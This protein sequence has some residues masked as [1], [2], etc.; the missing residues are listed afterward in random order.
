[1][2]FNTELLRGNGIEPSPKRE[3]VPP[4]SQTVSFQYERMEDLER[5]FRREKSGYAYTRVGNPTITALERRISDLERGFSAICCSSGMSALAAAILAIC[6]SGDEILA[7]N[8]FYGGTYDLFRNLDRLGIRTVFAPEGSD[9]REFVTERTR[10]IL[11]ELI[12]NPSLS[13]LDVPRVADVA[14][15][16]G[17]PLIVDSTTATPYLARPLELGASVVVHST[18]KYINGGGNS[19]GGVVVDGGKFPWD[20]ARFPTLAEYR[21]YGKYALS[22]ALRNDVCEN[23]GWALAPTGAFLTGIGLDTLGLRMERIC[24][25][26]DA[27]ANALAATGKVEVNY[28]TLPSHPCHKTAQRLFRGLGGGILSFRAGSK[29]RAFRIIN[30]LKRATI[31]SNLGD[32]RTLVIHPAS[33]LYLHSGEEAARAAG[34]FDD[35]VRVS[36]G[37][38][39]AEDLVEDFV[40]AVE[41]AAE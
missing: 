38:E 7:V 17:I 24:G 33:T 31:A 27:L 32:V 10:A 26:A 9:P 16:A 3:I 23:F 13:V 39:D 14:R 41:S 30:S 37:I 40:G 19:V 6:Q 5:V 8:G 20:F 4:I 11:G 28:L 21:K 22:A 18:T 12:A 36:V 25:N 1:M 2:R 34:V 15:E 29:E 35:T